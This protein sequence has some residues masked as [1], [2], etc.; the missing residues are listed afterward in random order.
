MDIDFLDMVP[1]PDPELLNIELSDWYS[2][3]LGRVV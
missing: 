1:D 3:E 2:M